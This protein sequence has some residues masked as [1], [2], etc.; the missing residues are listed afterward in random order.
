MERILAVDTNAAFHEEQ[1]KMLSHSLFCGGVVV[2][3]V[4]AVS[5]VGESLRE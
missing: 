2:L 5:S 1:G 3:L 4:R